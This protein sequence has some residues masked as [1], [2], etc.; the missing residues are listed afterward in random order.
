MSLRLQPDVVA[1]IDQR[2]TSSFGSASRPGLEP[3]ATL[4]R[5]RLSVRDHLEH[6]DRDP[7]IGPE[8]PSRTRSLRAGHA[9]AEGQA[10]RLS[11][12]DWAR[13]SFDR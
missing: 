2:A 9:N 5:M 13:S 4:V 7:A 6:R 3:N 1:S 12:S 8:P 10:V 11:S